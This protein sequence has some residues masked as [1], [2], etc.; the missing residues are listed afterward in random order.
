MPNE[1]KLQSLE[2]ARHRPKEPDVEQSTQI[3]SSDLNLLF[4]ELSDCEDAEL[5]S[6]IEGHQRLA[7]EVDQHYEYKLLV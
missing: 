6:R 4:Q 7:Q 1:K 3:A 2:G 5:M